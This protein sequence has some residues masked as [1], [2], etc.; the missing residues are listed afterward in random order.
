MHAVTGSSACVRICNGRS[1][2][3]NARDGETAAENELLLIPIMV[4]IMGSDT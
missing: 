4:K 1:G 2:N 3:R